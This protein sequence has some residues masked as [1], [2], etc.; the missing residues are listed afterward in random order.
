MMIEEMLTITYLGGETVLGIGVGRRTE[1]IDAG[2]AIEIIVADERIPESAI[3]GGGTILLTPD[4]GAGGRT[5]R[6]E[7]LPKL[8]ITSLTR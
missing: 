8:P 2:V 5:A 6:K 4:D 3:G 1:M 7:G